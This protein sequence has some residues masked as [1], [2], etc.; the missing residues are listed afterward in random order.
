[1]RLRIFFGA[2][3]AGI[4]KGSFRL[5]NRSFTPPVRNANLYTYITRTR[6]LLDRTLRRPIPPP[7]FNLTRPQRSFLYWLRHQ[8][9]LIVKPADKNMGI[10]IMDRSAYM[11]EAH[12]HLSDH[13][14]YQAIQRI[15]YLTWYQ[16]RL[17]TALT[18]LLR[19]LSSSS[20]SSCCNT[21]P[22]LRCHACTLFLRCTS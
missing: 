16:P 14:T 22:P 13:T 4:R 5:P 2:A 20:V 6:A 11:A 3:P 10:A 15:R 18:D 7:S 12:R 19:G 8:H 1:M 17:L 9:E 21:A